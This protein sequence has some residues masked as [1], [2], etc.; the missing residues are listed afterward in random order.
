MVL[1]AACQAYEVWIGTLG[2]QQRMHDHPNEWKRTAAMVEGLNVNW[3]P[4]V[5][6][7]GRL[8]P[9]SRARVI[10]MLEIAKE[11]AS[12]VLPHRKGTIDDASE[13]RRP[14]DLANSMGYRLKHLYT[15]NGGKGRT[16][17]AAE[18]GLLRS[19]LDRNGH[20]EVA[21]AFNAR[22]GHGQL[23]RPVIQ[24]GGIEC[25]LA[26]WGENK[27]SRHE[28]L[29]WMTDPSNPAMRG[30]KSIIHCHLNRGHA[31]DPQDL[32]GV[33]AAARLMVRDV[34]RD[35]MNTPELREVF[36]SDKLVF[37]FFGGNWTS[38]GITLLPETK[39]ENTYAESY[40]GLLLSLLEQR[41]R[42]E[43][44]SGDFPS[45]DWC[46][47]FERN[48]GRFNAAG[49]HAGG[50]KGPEPSVATPPSKPEADDQAGPDSRALRMRE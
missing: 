2:W 17:S 10:A 49:S 13:W 44:R 12:Q 27:G 26:S 29:R 41:D 24:G 47:S 35:V 9:E 21:I 19:W 4:G 14:F 28:L 20:G 1:P 32:V 48:S 5:T 30:E 16:W 34:G 23:E 42:F 22:S 18:H 25:D 31:S 7:A 37:A 43:G 33:W 50:G 38:S 40:T 36:R 3:G 45:D 8:K 6:D 11:N 39:D 46:A 15:Y